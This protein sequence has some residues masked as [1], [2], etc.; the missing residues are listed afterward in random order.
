MARNE[1]PPFGRGE[2]FY[3]GGTITADT[4]QTGSAKYGGA[5]MEGKEWDFED[6][7]YNVTGQVGAKPNRT[8]RLVRCRICRNVS[9]INLLP[10]RLANFCLAGT[11]PALNGGQDFGSQVDGYASTTAQFVAGVIDE[12]L[13]AAGV[14]PDDLFWLVVRGPT[15]VLTDLAGGVNNLIAIGDVLVALTAAT[16]QATTAGRV[17]EQVL[18][19]ATSP[20]ALQA[21][22]YIGRALSAATTANTNA[23]LLVEIRQLY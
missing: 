7:S 19:G 10:S 23:L 4:T 11:S 14:P 1:N 20:L 18:T 13:P 6:I 3:N 17:G 16:S 2:T 22:N 9:G 21:M 8:N 15:T 12:W 5:Q